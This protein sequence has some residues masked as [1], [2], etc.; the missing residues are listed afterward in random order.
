MP[1]TEPN[2]IE[3]LRKVRGSIESK[4]H[5]AAVNQAILLLNTIASFLEG[6]NWNSE[7]AE[8]IADALRSFGFEIQCP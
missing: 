7:T 1:I 4:E 5:A 3:Q 8:S 2:I 6:G